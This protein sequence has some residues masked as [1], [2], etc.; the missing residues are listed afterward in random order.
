MIVESNGNSRIVKKT[1]SRPNSRILNSRL[2]PLMVTPLMITGYPS[3][4]VLNCQVQCGVH[5]AV[6]CSTVYSILY[7]VQCVQCAMYTSIYSNSAVSYTLYC[8]PRTVYSA[9]YT[10]Y[11]AAYTTTYAVQYVHNVYYIATCRSYNLDLKLFT[12]PNCY[13]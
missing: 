4:V 8:T 2:A 10:V 1:N 11:S 7:T 12:R 3:T 9:V 5:N 6:S 13:V